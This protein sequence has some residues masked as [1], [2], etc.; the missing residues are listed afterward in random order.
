MHIIINL[1]YYLLKKS[2]STNQHTHINY[3]IISIA[4][5]PFSSLYS[6]SDEF[7]LEFVVMSSVTMWD[8]FE[9]CELG[10]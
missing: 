5:S 8:P 7:G 2:L 6:Y 3:Y 1:N 10:F 9:L 4:S